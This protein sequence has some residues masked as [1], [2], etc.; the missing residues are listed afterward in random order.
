MRERVMPKIQSHL[1]DAGVSQER[2]DKI[3]RKK[4]ERTIKTPVC[5]PD[6]FLDEQAKEAVRLVKFQFQEP[7]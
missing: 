6:S 5:K 4:K 1:N 3:F 2:W 7:K